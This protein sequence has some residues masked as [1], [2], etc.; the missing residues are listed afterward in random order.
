LPRSLARLAGVVII[1]V[2][3]VAEDVLVLEVAEVLNPRFFEDLV[4]GV[5]REE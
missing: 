2:V 5:E 3:V 1:V 4:A